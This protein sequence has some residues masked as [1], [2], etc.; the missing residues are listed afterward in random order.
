M[1]PFSRL[2]LSAIVAIA[3]DIPDLAS[4]H[5]FRLTSPACA[6]AF[7]DPEIVA[8]IVELTARDTL[9]YMN[10]KVFGYIWALLQKPESE[11]STS[12]GPPIRIS[13][14]YVI[15]SWLG[16]STP[17]IESTLRI[18]VLA[19][20]IHHAAHRCLHTLL[21]RFTALRPC[22]P[23]N[24]KF[25]LKAQKFW[26]YSPNTPFMPPPQPRGE[27]AAINLQ[28]AAGPLQWFE[29][30]NAVY[31]ALLLA[32]YA[33]VRDRPK[34]DILPP[35]ESTIEHLKA[36]KIEASPKAAMM[37]Q[38]LLD[39]STPLT[40]PIPHKP[41]SDLFPWAPSCS[42]SGCSVAQKWLASFERLHILRKGQEF[43]DHARKT[44]WS[45]I[46]AAPIGPFLALGFP[47]WGEYRLMD[48]GLLTGGAD[49]AKYFA[50][51]AALVECSDMYA[52]KSVL[53]LSQLEDLEDSQYE[54]WVDW[55]QDPT[56]WS[57]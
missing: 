2:P 25:N 10:Q 50:N 34:P 30:Q 20:N 55:Q 23:Y 22:R 36:L 37:Q 1:D 38:V 27:L 54:A 17:T 9:E 49:K 33:V 56:N 39:K 28:A 41:L 18:L 44:P 15:R 26:R 11:W 48:M 13:A 35:S 52:W 46:R 24:A 40:S 42:Q 8:D 45:A 4:L 31:G 29:E 57:A 51:N 47:I 43:F 16:Y 53:T 19:K 21:Q 14:L 12:L 5:S 3:T 32:L 6:A 7:K